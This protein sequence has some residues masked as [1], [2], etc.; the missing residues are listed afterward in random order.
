MSATALPNAA[1]HVVTDPAVCGG[2]PCVAGT[3]VRVLD[4]YVWHDLRGQSADE[5]VGRFP[6]LT[7]ADVYAALTYFWDH[8]D[9]MLADLERD[10][11][12]IGELR[13][14][15]PSKLAATTGRDAVSP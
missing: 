3:R 14:R 5:I 4:V 6:H 8:R 15:F 7:H 9:A 12:L 2:K 10:D 11:H 1:D 13:Q